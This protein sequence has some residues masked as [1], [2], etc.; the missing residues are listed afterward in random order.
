MPTGKIKYYNQDKGY[1]FIAQDEGED[2]FF[3]ILKSPSAGEIKAGQRV[4]YEVTR[5]K[6]GLEA[7]NIQLM[8]TPFEQR[9][10]S[11]GKVVVS[12]DTLVWTPATDIRSRTRQPEQQ[13]SVQ[14]QVTRPA[15]SKPSPK[16]SALKEVKKPSPAPKEAVP[17]QKPTVKAPLVEGKVPAEKT[18]QEV[19]PQE[20]VEKKPAPK[21]APKQK[22][23]QRPKKEV[24]PAQKPPV[25]T[26]LAE[27]KKLPEEIKHEVKPQEPVSQETQ[28]EPTPATKPRK[29]AQQKR[30]LTYCDRYM[31]KQIREKTPMVFEMYNH[32]SIFCTVDKLFK[33]DLELVVDGGEKTK[34]QKHNIKY[35]YKQENA[36]KV[37][38]S[39][40]FDESVRSQGLMPIIKRKERYQ[41]DHNMV[42]ETWAKRG[43][44]RLVTREGEIIIG[45]PNWFSIYDIK[46]SLPLGG[47]VVT[48]FHALYDFKILSDG[49]V[50]TLS[51]QELKPI[52]IVV[53]KQV[54]HS[55]E[56]G[57]EVLEEK[58]EMEVAPPASVEEVTSKS[59]EE[60]PTPIPTSTE[61]TSLSE[62]IRTRRKA[63][64]MSQKDL[65]E[66]LGVST[67][68]IGNWEKGKS[69][70]QAKYQ[71][72]IEQLFTAAASGVS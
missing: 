14:K 17:L 25:K 39:I 62:R 13:P 53:E 71:E 8:L 4:K 1:G 9:K 26:S 65:A 60:A 40:S 10:L 31:L 55:I 51:E 11:Q 35:C 30:K 45:S 29:K 24:A 43:K 52:P 63:L 28:K 27:E 48:F 57:K 66:S 18:K 58:Q 47:N 12:R 67:Q 70:P 41:I 6:K 19:K 50:S 5:G 37:K 34:I 38:A 22:E 21:E 3:H 69:Q 54:E 36:E 2:L 64:G 16:P 20:L 68:T 44:V 59:Q 46:V 7:E 15:P 49:E 32:E 33:Y 72:Q 61:E 56:N 42:K 23:P